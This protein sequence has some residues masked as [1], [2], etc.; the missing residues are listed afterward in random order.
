MFKRFIQDET[1]ATAIE[2]ALI[3]TMGS[4]GIIGALSALGVEYESMYS[5]IAT[6][7]VENS[8]TPGG[9]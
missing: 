4:I 6:T 1:G 9:P 2:Y 5:N 8:G 7:L 3:L